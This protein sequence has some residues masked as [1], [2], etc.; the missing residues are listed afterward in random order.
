MIERY[1]L[2]LVGS[3]HIEAIRRSAGRIAAQLPAPGLPAASE[4]VAAGCATVA[5]DED[6]CAAL[7]ARQFAR[8][9][10]SR[11]VARAAAR[12]GPDRPELRLLLP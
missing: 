10:S 7:A 1:A 6:A 8:F 9:A 4:L 5:A 2:R 3:P 11:L 12:H